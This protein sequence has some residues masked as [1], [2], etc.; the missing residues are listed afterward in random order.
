MHKILCNESMPQGIQSKDQSSF[1]THVATCSGSDYELYC[2]P[3]LRK[4]LCGVGAW[5]VS[6]KWLGVYIP[7]P[8]WWLAVSVHGAQRTNLRVVCSQPPW[9]IHRG[10]QWQHQSLRAIPTCLLVKIIKATQPF[11]S[12][13]GVG[14]GFHCI[15]VEIRVENKWRFLPPWSEIFE[16]LVKEIL[17]D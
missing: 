13:D 17:W 11:I 7:T 15:P 1:L 10:I 4:S 6:A 12:Y 16:D 8:R 14:L 3:G 5:N 2:V 9:R